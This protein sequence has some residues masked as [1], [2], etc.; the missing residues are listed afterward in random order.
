MSKLILF[1]IAFSGGAASTIQPSI[2]SR[3]A[4]K[5]GFLGSSLISFAVGTLTLALVVFATDAGAMRGLCRA[6]WWELTG[7]VLGAF[8]VATITFVVPRIGT[9][10]A[11]ASIIAAQLTIGMVLD[12]FGL[13]GM[14]TVAI[15]LKRLAGAMLLLAGVY[16]IFRG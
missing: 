6:R 15:D 12:H 14:Q 5:V 2:N 1:L 16:L 13:F 11:M 3:L 8:F 10:A 4:M 7:G 9:T